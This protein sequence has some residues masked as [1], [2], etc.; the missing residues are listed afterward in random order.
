MTIGNI[1]KAQMDVIIERAAKRRG[2]HPEQIIIQ[3]QLGGKVKIT[4]DP[5]TVL[6]SLELEE[7]LEKYS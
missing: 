4:T 5:Q 1:V 2:L 7:L 6:E 3:Y